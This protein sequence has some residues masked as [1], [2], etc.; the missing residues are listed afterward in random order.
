MINMFKKLNAITAVL[1]AALMLTI[2]ANAY[3]ANDMAAFGQETVNVYKAVSVPVLDGVINDGEYNAP[4]RVVNYGDTA[5]Y[6]NGD[7]SLYTKDELEMILPG[8]VS[9][10]A[11]YDENNLYIACVNTDNNH[12]TPLTGG[13]VWDGDYLEFDIGTELTEDFACYSNKLRLAIGMSSSDG[14]TCTYS[15]KNPD[16]AAEAFSMSGDLPGISA[17]SRDDDA[18]LTTYEAVIPWTAITADGKAP[19]NAFFY[20]QLGIGDED[21]VD[22]SEYAAYLGVYRYASP[23]DEAMKAEVGVGVIPNIMTFAGDAPVVDSTP[24]E[25]SESAAQ[26]AD[27]ALISVAVMMLSAAVIAKAK[28]K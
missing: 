14:S 27:I 4:I 7:E 12:F 13:D 15:A 9:F 10:Y 19:E 26:T 17:I 28:A 22:C 21:F 5:M 24:D 16:N 25:T 18:G 2:A 20:Y 11:C 3:E 8:I 1:M 6:F 23:L